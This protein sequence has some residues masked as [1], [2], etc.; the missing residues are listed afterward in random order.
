MTRGNTAASE[1]ERYKNRAENV[2]K[3]GG[4][5][6]RLKNAR[7]TTLIMQAAVNFDMLCAC[8]NERQPAAPCC[9]WGQCH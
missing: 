8:P 4:G 5:V 9:R 2:Y 1:N 3:C 7:R 6:S